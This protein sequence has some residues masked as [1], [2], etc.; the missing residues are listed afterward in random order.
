MQIVRTFFVIINME[1]GFDKCTTKIVLKR[2]KLVHWQNVTI[3]ISRE[4]H[5]LSRKKRTSDSVLSNVAVCNVN[6]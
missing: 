6:K 3:G 2:G 1:L 4:I 5:E